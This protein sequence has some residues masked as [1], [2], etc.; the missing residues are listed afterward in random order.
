MPSCAANGK[1]LSLRWLQGGLMIVMFIAGAC[2]LAGNTTV[3]DGP[4]RTEGLTPLPPATLPATIT[5]T[6]TATASPT[7]TRTPTSTGTF[8]PIPTVGSL[9]AAVTADLLSC[10]YGPG[11]N[12]LFL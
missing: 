12:Y 2:T 9:K 6:A 11:A 5:A 10:R 4:T 7:K 8:T 3:P 1:R